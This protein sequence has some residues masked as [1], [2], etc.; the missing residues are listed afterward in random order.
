M[1]KRYVSM[2]KRKSNGKSNGLKGK[3]HQK[4]HWV[5]KRKRR[6]LAYQVG[7]RPVWARK[8]S[9]LEYRFISEYLVDLNKSEAYLRATQFENYQPKKGSNSANLLLRRNHV[10]EALESALEAELDIPKTR[11]I[12]ELSAIAFSNPKDFISWDDRG[13]VKFKAS[14]KIR[15]S[16]MAAVQEAARTA[17]GLRIKFVDKMPALVKLASILGI[18]KEQEVS[19]PSLTINI[20][21]FGDSDKIVD[22]TPKV[23]PM[24]EDKRDA[25][26]TQ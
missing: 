5:N 14:D 9:R 11:I 21:R 22:V 16:K 15:D 3:R 10:K 24:I 19:S 18:S 7:R 17:N 8:L 2:K 4:Y 26:Q 6:K 1:V 25:T 23:V 20:V 13:A 12:D